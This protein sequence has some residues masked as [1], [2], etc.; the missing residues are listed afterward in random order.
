[1]VCRD[2]LDE[3]HLYMTKIEA[4]LKQLVLSTLILIMALLVISLGSVALW[5]FLAAARKDVSEQVRDNFLNA[6]NAENIAG[7]GADG[8]SGRTSSTITILPNGRTEAQGGG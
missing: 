8:Y 3:I 5:K 2:E 6:L 1:M 4:Y 7:L